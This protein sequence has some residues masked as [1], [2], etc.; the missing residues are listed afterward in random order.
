MERRFGYHC[1]S[2]GNIVESARTQPDGLLLRLNVIESGMSCNWVFAI[3]LA[4][5]RVS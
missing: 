1:E 4:Q 5:L 2:G 3:P